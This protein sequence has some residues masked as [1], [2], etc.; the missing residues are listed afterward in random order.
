MFNLKIN[1]DTLLSYLVYY[2]LEKDE[3]EPT[4][5]VQNS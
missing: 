2:D 3:R 5:A 1:I 4:G